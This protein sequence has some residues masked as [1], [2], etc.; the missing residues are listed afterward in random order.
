MILKVLLVGVVIAIVYF[1]FIKKK[2]SKVTQES[3]KKKD[4]AKANDMVE[5]ASCGVY[6][7]LKECI[8]SDAKYYCSKECLAKAS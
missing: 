3:S 6:S 7:E 4:E 5:C 2:P 1:T 8:L